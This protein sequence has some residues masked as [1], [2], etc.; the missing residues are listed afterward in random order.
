MGQLKGENEMEKNIGNFGSV[1][2]VAFSFTFNPWL[3]IAG[4]SAITVQT[5]KAKMYNLSIVN[6]VS[7][8]G[9]IFQLSK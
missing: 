4:L 3:A 6:V 2:M 8:I 9:F 1:L 5:Q 7:I